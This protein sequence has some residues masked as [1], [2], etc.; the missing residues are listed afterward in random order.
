MLSARLPSTAACDDPAH[1][2]THNGVTQA[3]PGVE[4]AGFGNLPAGLRLL[5]LGFVARSNQGLRVGILLAGYGVGCRQRGI[6]SSRIL[7][8]RQVCS[9]PCNVGI[10]TCDLGLRSSH[11]RQKRRL[12]MFWCGRT[13]KTP[14][15]RWSR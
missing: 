13:L 2:R 5:H 6:A 7:C 8:L 10:G 9:S 11:L 1:R 12:S 3:Y 15:C 4:Q 14:G